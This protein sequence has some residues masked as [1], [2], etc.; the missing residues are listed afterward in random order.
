MGKADRRSINNK[1]PLPIVLAIIIVTILAGGGWYFFS[2][3]KPKPIVVSEPA[4]EVP[5]EL[6]QEPEPAVI[7]PSVEPAPPEPKIE[8]VQE[9]T[10]CEKVSEGIKKYFSYL[11]KQEYIAARKFAIGSQDHFSRL[12]DKLIAKP[13]I[14]SRE[15]E[16]LHS[17]L[18]NTAH[19]YRI[20]RKED[21]FLMR[22]I[23]AKEGSTIE[24]TL[25]LFY[26]WSELAAECP[27][28]GLQV[29]LPL[30][31]LYE[32]AGFFLNTLG[33]QSYLF[34][35]ESRIRMLIKYYSI[36]VMDRANTANINRYGIDIRPS[37]DSLLEEM[38]TAASLASKE[39]YLAQLILLQDKYQQQYGDGATSAPA[40]Q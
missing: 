29:H 17:I 23:L 22:D 10:E 3:Q 2:Q 18:K 15:T 30:P 40:G 27:Q 4:P 8:V 21:V 36:L 34:R 7:E 5:V 19:F 13:P 31:G 37:I 28:T 16:S 33:G 24:P 25:A 9:K 6:P 20:L 38:K 1:S 26:K 32:Y 14:I 35:R 11:D 12:I 39:E